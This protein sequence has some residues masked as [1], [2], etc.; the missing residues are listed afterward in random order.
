MKAGQRLRAVSLVC[1]QLLIIGVTVWAAAHVLGRLAV[2][3]I[4]LSIA[5]LLTALLRPPSS[6]LIRRGVPRGLA[7]ALV[8]VLAIGLV[9]GFIAF[10]SMSLVSALP[11]L[12]NRLDDSLE[13][14]RGWLSGVGW[15]E[16]ALT[17]GREWLER[18]RQ[19][20]ASGALGV[21]ATAGSALGGL[22]FVLFITLFLVHDGRR[23][24]RF[25][26]RAVPAELRPRVHRGGLRAFHDLSAYMRASIAVALIDA[27]GIGLGLWVLDVPLVLPLA[28]LV[29]LGGFVPLLGALVS[30][31]VCAL[32]ALVSGGPVTALMVVGVVVVVQQLEGNVL[33]PLLMG[34]AVR[35]HPLAV[36]LAV[37]A[38]GSQAGV[39]G[40]VL[41]V[42]LVTTVRAFVAS[43]VHS[44]R[45]SARRSVGHLMSA[46]ETD[47]DGASGG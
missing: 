7:T 27:V 31:A 5:V 24:W 34:G 40:A 15:G 19:S 47:D 39:I 35:L 2:V 32:V 20:L 37:A 26:L 44:R 3:V 21:F 8:M 28:A 6:W 18:N 23:V 13:Q 46:A 38:G 36:I 41:A 42:P 17:Q 30:G 16:Q 11:D 22:V 45:S 4:P 33:E 1:L 43:E 14:V 12:Q 29:F 9:G 10:I 25:V